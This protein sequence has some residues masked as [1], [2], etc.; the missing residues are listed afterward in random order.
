MGGIRK[1]KRVMNRQQMLVDSQIAF[2]GC[3]VLLLSDDVRDGKMF[4]AFVGHLS[5]RSSIPNMRDIY[6]AHLGLKAKFEENLRSS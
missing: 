2:N 4:K 1:V 6:F 5:A 3:K